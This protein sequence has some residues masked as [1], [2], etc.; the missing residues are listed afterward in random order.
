MP[1][2]E[3][4]QAAI[5]AGYS[6]D[7]IVAA[8]KS[9]PK[10][11]PPD[12]ITA[13][14]LYDAGSSPETLRA[15][16][17][18]APMKPP[19]PG[20]LDRIKAHPLEEAGK[21]ALNIGQMLTRAADTATFGGYSKA[22]NL[23]YG[24]VSPRLAGETQA[25]DETF[26]REHPYMASTGDALGYVTP[27]G[28]P[29]L[30]ARGVGRAAGAASRAVGPAAEGLAGRVIGGAGQ[31]AATGGA[32]AGAE[33]AAAGAPP[34]E[35]GSS[36]LG[37]AEFGG[38]MG[39]ALGAAGAARAKLGRWADKG[40][41]DRNLSD[42]TEGGGAA[43]RDRVVGRGGEKADRIDSLARRTPALDAAAGDPMKQGP[44]VQ[45]EI[46]RVGR[47]LDEVYKGMPVPL[48]VL[49]AP[50]RAMANRLEME[51]GIENKSRAAHLR[52]QADDYERT[53]A[54]QSYRALPVGK[55]APP[56]PGE[57][58]QVIPR[59]T[60]G[61]LIGNPG[62]RS[63]NPPQPPGRPRLPAPQGGMIDAARARELATKMGDGLFAGNPNNLDIGASKKLGRE[64]YGQV[65]DML[66]T[67]A[68]R[69]KPGIRPELEAA[70]AEMS[71][72]LNIRNAVTARAAR[73]QTPSMTGKSIVGKGVD[74]ILAVTHPVGYVAKHGLE[75]F[76]PGL[77]RG[78]QNEL[79]A[80]P[81]ALA[82]SNPLMRAAGQWSQDRQRQ[83]QQAQAQA[84]MQ[85]AIQENQRKAQDAAVIQ[86]IF[87]ATP[88]K[89]QQSDQP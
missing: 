10:A 80:P 39:G 19:E 76:G 69:Q 15:R 2:K 89:E 55:V 51:P 30:I 45:G 49:T 64:L 11:L 58:T 35:I 75:H 23:A 67:V 73:A 37:G 21:G 72:W 7:E 5:E 68:E 4:L 82:T 66:N 17:D 14:E 22:R 50:M 42:L 61:E 62:Q 29:E 83:A 46:D 9:A 1:T 63:P 12:Q 74:T 16:L 6:D 41:T 32:I 24:A 56:M 60:M 27:G 31:G 79:A 53:L 38:V 18:E 28:G 84:G 47:Q 85:Q 71:D 13:K 87:G 26:G 3:Q 86:S 43:K 40:I 65:V 78:L 77:S 48:D 25:A 34:S 36:A 81:G 44:I 70:N 88:G 54:P 20:L 52:A 59:Q 57:A 33:A 8:L